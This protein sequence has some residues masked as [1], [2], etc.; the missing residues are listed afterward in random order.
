MTSPS[1]WEAY[2]LEPPRRGLLVHRNRE[3]SYDVVVFR[4]DLCDPTGAGEGAQ[5][6]VGGAT[7]ARSE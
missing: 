5:S 6:N 4:N 1:Y 7:Q 3:N 2:S